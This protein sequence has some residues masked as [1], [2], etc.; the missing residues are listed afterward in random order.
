MSGLVFKLGDA[1][2]LHREGGQMIDDPR[3]ERRKH[4]REYFYTSFTLISELD[5]IVR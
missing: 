2:D 5:S 1:A 4:F 3:I